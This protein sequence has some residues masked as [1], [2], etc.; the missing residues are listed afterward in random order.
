MI[1]SQILKLVGIVPQVVELIE[2]KSIVDELVA[3]MPQNALGEQ[4]A[5]AEVLGEARGVLR[6]CRCG[7]GEQVC[8]R[9]SVE[10]CWF[11]VFVLGRADAG[12]LQQRWEQIDQRYVRGRLGG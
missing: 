3:P 6:G 1:D 10:R 2:I 8:E 5:C 11:A 7:R 12:Q 4:V 9:P